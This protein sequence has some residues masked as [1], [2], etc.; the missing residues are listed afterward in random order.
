MIFTS[1]TIYIRA[2]KMKLLLRRNYKKTLKIIMSSHILK[3]IS[4]DY[5]VKKKK[6]KT[7]LYLFIYFLNKIFT[8][9]L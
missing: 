5:E 8:V 2:R 4:K 6:N 1:G 3:I 7:W 9:N